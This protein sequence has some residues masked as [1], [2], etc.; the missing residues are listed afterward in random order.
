[1]QRSI[2]ALGVLV[3]V[4]GCAVETGTL[5]L[6]PAEPDASV[7]VAGSEV[8]LVPAERAAEGGAGPALAAAAPD[9][10]VA[11]DA[12]PQRLI[13]LTVGEAAELLGRPALV[14]REP[15][16]EV[17]QYAGSECVLHL[18]LY[19]RENGGGPAV[20]HFEMRGLNGISRQACLAT[21]LQALGASGG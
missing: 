11:V 14:R 6:S 21:H 17:W 19:E 12:D 9:P 10:A 2:L 13:G 8:E 15:P 20:T 7:A 3:T 18:F 5:R 4:A 1:M 16:A